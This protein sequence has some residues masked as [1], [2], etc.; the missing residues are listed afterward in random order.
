MDSNR[1]TYLS[2]IR[3]LVNLKRLYLGM[4]KIQEVEEI[5]KL[6]TL[7]SLVEISMIGNGLA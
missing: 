6:R 1:L 4:N 7:T 3:P 2:N 5:A